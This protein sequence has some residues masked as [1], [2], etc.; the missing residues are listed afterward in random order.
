MHVNRFYLALLHLQMSEAQTLLSVD[1]VFGEHSFRRQ[2]SSVRLN[3][4]QQSTIYPWMKG[5]F[6]LRNCFLAPGGRFLTE[7][8]LDNL[9]MPNI[10]C[11]TMSETEGG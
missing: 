9:K 8:L 5:S 2:P 6:C 10:A 3:V 4:L 11:E 1:V 7:G